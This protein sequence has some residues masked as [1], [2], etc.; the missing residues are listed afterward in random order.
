MDNSEKFLGLLTTTYE[1]EA[2]RAN[3]NGV[4]RRRHMAT[5]VYDGD[6]S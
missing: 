6:D 1:A 2:T 4:F 5:S 3:N